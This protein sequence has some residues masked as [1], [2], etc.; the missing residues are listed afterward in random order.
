M[1]E[2]YD[3]SIN[4]DAKFNFLE[5]IDVPGLVASNK[6]EWNNQTLCQVND[7]VVRLGIMQ[8]EFVSGVVIFRPKGR[9]TKRAVGG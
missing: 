9:P 8:G 1:E 4:L 3:Y 2:N 6:E 7:C 5:L